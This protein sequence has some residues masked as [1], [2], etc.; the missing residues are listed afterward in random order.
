MIPA[1]LSPI[2]KYVSKQESV[3]DN[4][5][6]GYLENIRND[7]K[8][9]LLNSEYNALHNESWKYTSLK[10]LKNINLVNQ[11]FNDS[12]L[13][14]ILDLKNIKKNLEN[15]SLNLFFVNGYF[16]ET[17][18]SKEVNKFFS[19]LDV[20]MS[21][22]SNHQF[23]SDN[24]AQTIGSK[25]SLTSCLNRSF[26]NTGGVFKITKDLGRLQLNII[27]ITTSEDQ[28]VIN[29]PRYYIIL[30]EGAEA[31]VAEK[32]YGFC[33]NT[34]LTNPLSE[35]IISSGALLNHLYIV[36]QNSVGFHVG[37]TEISLDNESTYNG[38]V[39]CLGGMLTRY[40]VYLLINGQR[41]K[42]TVNG[43]YCLSNN[44][45]VDITSEIIH[46]NEHSYSNQYIKGIVKDKSKG[47]FQGKI[48]VGKD[49]NGTEANQMHKALLLEGN[50]E[51]DC[52]PELEIF[53]ENVKC[54]HG[55][56]TGELDK[57][58]LFYLTSRGISP[59]NAR[60]LLIKGFFDDIF[61]GTDNTSLLRS[62]KSNLSE[63]IEDNI[64]I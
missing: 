27:S 44:Q 55:A 41:S 19:S 21:S 52:K 37:R 28:S 48:H 14:D 51:I 15:D 49:G 20:F 30:E 22:K 56:T 24:F 47:V 43:L 57:D 9:I 17:L 40:E 35:V 58:Q 11:R 7:S 64:L 61:M 36:D 25:P 8:N 32:H 39:M 34:Y 18:S 23:T 50:P 42:A 29:H 4:V 31:T 16:S 62:L 5:D 1:I 3:L 53:A 54:S 63:W 46:K 38:L 59:E 45:H 10:S 26:F 12:D 33:K 60:L 13:K 2:E 6:F